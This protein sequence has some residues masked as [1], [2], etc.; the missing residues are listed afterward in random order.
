[1]ESDEKRTRYATA[2]NWHW[3]ITREDIEKIYEND[4]ETI[5]RVYFANLSKFGRIA[6]KYI[7]R[8]EDNS[9]YS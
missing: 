6:N 8:K 2:E 9:L 3:I 1:M 5:N 7:S 4:R